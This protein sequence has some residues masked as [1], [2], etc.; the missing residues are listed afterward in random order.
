MSAAEQMEQDWP[1]TPEGWAARWQAEISAARKDAEQWH[2]RGRKIIKRYLD[3]REGEQNSQTRLNLFTSNT[4]TMQSLLYGRTPEVSVQRR[5]ADQN[6]DEARVAS[7]MLE[8][9]L[10]TDLEK[11]SDTTQEAYR[12]ALQDRLLP[13][14]GNVR[15]RYTCEWET[16]PET[17]AILDPETGAELAPAVPAQEVK[18]PGSE[19]VAIDYT[20]WRDQLWSPAK[21]FADLRWW[22]FKAEMPKPAL[23]KTFGENVAALLPMN[24]RMTA[25]DDKQTFK[26]PLAR[27][28]VWEIWDHANRCVW[29][30][31]DGYSKVLAPQGAGAQENGSVPDPLGLDGFWPFPRPMWAN[32][33]TSK[34]MPVPDFV[35]AQDLYN[36]ID[37]LATRIKLLEDAVSVRGLYNKNSEGVQRLLQEGGE[38]ELIPVDG[39]AAFAEKGGIKGA[40]DWLPLEMV[41]SAIQ[42]LGEQLQGKIAMLF[43]ITGM[44]D[45]MRG[46]ASAPATATEQAIKARFASVRVQSLQDEFARFASDTQR[47]KA[48][49]ISKHFDPQTIVERSNVLRTPDAQFAGP[50][51]ELI[52]SKFMDLRISVNPDA[53]SLTDFAALKA[54]RFE[55]MQSMSGFIQSAMPLAQVMPGSAPFLLQI[56]QWALAGLKGSSTIEGVFDQA[57]AAIEK[58]Q[59]APQQPPPPDPKV[60]AA[61]IKGQAEMGKAKMEIAG[62]GVDMEIAKMKGAIDMQKAG[63]DLQLKQLQIAE[64]Q[65]KAEHEAAKREHPEGEA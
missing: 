24:S 61:K 26:D 48:E 17:A 21:V 13:G 49:I 3:D 7:E 36:Q 35:M 11:D 62:K 63:L 46:Q 27:C 34:L 47:L 25:V 65:A 28:D 44:S 12:N 4:Q 41:V 56:M 37:N 53:V 5:F 1:D 52:K 15:L 19:N 32:L 42:I 60:E 59:S 55:F 39:W 45:I 64:H 54:E 18:K 22:A 23:V 16:Q 51:V 8:R 57:I 14:L 40:I 29:W 30:W 2:E 43:Q 6:D 10:N 31:V 50:A 33:T 20:Y 58:Q 9:L 38:N